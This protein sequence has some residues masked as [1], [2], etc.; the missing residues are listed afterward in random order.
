MAKLT[1]DGWDDVEAM[2]E[3]P[4][5]SKFKFGMAFGLMAELPLGESGFAIQPEV[6][7]VMKG[8]KAGFPEGEAEGYDITMKVKMDYVEVPVLIKYNF[9]TQGTISPNLFAGP[10]VAFN[11]AAKVE[12]EGYPVEAGE[13]FPSEDIENKKSVDFGIAFGGGL[14]LAVG[15]TGKLTFDVRYTLGLADLFDDISESEYDE[16]KVYFANEKDGSALAFKNSD[17]RLM[18]GFFF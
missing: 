4:I 5:D 2:M 3:T 11:V 18:V 12:S 16:D 6:L 9:P 8:G 10:V 1:G 13:D 15:E 7:Y 17:I 14:G